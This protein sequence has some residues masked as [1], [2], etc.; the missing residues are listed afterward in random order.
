MENLYIQLLF[1]GS[2]AH[3]GAQRESS[4]DAYTVLAGEY[5]DEKFPEHLFPDFHVSA[6]EGKCP[7]LRDDEWP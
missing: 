5:T 2:L 1:T 3:R 6:A 4:L 7:S